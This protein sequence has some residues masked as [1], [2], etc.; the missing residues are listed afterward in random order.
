MKVLVFN[1]VVF[2]CDHDDHEHKVAFLLN[3][4]TRITG[5]KDKDTCFI[6]DIEVDKSFDEI[7][8]MIEYYDN[9]DYDTFEI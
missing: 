6:N 3:N 5:R 4:I 1:R 9:E 2:S 8:Q 7:I